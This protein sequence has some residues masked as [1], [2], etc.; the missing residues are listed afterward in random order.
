MFLEGK[1]GEEVRVEPDLF[2]DEMVPLPIDGWQV[3]QERKDAITFL[4]IAG[5]RSLSGQLLSPRVATVELLN[6]LRPT[7]AVSVYLTFVAHALHQYPEYRR[8]LEVGED[9]YADLFVQEVRRLY[10]FFPAVMARVRRL[11]LEGVPLPRG[12]RVMPDL[13]GTN[14]DARTWDAPKEFR[15]ER[16]CQWDRSAFNFVP[17]G[18]GDHHVNHRCA[19]EWITIE[20]MKVASDVLTKRIKYEMP[21]QDLGIDLSRFPALPKSRFR[22]SNVRMTFDYQT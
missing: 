22:I 4:V 12:R 17:Q 15:P 21:E 1:S 9:G 2:F 11:R 7:V 5:L 18:G 13:Y 20:L 6:V 10:P 3:V 16:F 8:R 19:G 14:H